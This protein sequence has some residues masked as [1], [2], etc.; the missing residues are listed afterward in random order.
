MVKSKLLNTYNF[1]YLNMWNK[2]VNEFDFFGLSD[3]IQD[4]QNKNYLER[5]RRFE[6]E[7]IDK[8]KGL[9]LFKPNEM[10]IS[11]KDNRKS[12]TIKTWK[13]PELVKKQRKKR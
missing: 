2:R 7:K 10:L 1:P 9:G 5:K 3:S 4:P 13:R 11:M 12:F 8:L 6:N